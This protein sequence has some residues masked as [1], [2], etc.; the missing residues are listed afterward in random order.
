MSKNKKYSNEFKLMVVK[1]YLDG[2]GG[3]KQLTKKHNISTDKLVRAWVNQYI[4]F[5]DK[6]LFRARNHNEY[7]V[8][9]KL[10]ALELHETTEMS[11]RQIANRLKI[12]NP[13][14]ISSWKRIFNE[15]GI[16]GFNKK[17]GRPTMN[18]PSKKAINSKKSSRDVSK[19]EELK[20]KIKELEYE[21]RLSNIKNEYLEML[22]SLGQKQIKK[23]QE[24]STNSDNDTN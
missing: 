12:T 7:T 20:E 13:S 8:E 9:L 6:G 3:Y 24:S 5:G 4:N 22:R 10:Q 2:K 15:E 16:S 18:K 17:K 21:L 14:I 1:E 19:E 11:F 23:K